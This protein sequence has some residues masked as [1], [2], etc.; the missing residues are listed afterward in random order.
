MAGPIDPA[1]FVMSSEKIILPSI[2]MVKD[3]EELRVI[4]GGLYAGSKSWSNDY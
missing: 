3:W 1:Y 4:V 2:E